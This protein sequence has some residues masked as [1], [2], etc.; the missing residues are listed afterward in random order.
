[1]IILG[2]RSDRVWMA[3]VVCWLFVSETLGVCCAPDGQKCGR[4]RWNYLA[5]VWKPAIISSLSENSTLKRFFSPSPCHVISPLLLLSL[6]PVVLSVNFLRSNCQP[7]H[8]LL[9]FLLPLLFLPPP[10]PH[11]LPLSISHLP[12]TTSV[13]HRVCCGSPFGFHGHQW[14]VS[15]R[16]RAAD[17]K[18]TLSQAFSWKWWCPDCLNHLPNPTVV[19]RV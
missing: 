19:Y 7:D 5:R 10:H 14:S 11:S 12:L 15:K 9:S 6:L 17:E 13:S 1:M 2:I 16:T 4:G 8:R 18:W 3:L